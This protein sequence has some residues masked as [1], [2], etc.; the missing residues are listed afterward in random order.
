[1]EEWQ[2]DGLRDMRKREDRVR[3]RLKKEKGR[4]M[5]ECK[6]ESTEKDRTKNEV[7]DDWLYYNS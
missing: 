6:D 4:V 2:G 3:R 1:M 5:K 7:T